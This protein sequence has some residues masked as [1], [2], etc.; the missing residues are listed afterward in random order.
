RAPGRPAGGRPRRS[1]AALLG[2]G[3]SRRWPAYLAAA[4]LIAAIPPLLLSLGT[5]F[6]PEMDEGSL[7][8][9]FNSPPG[10][11]AS[12]TE[13]ILAG[14][15]REIAATPE[16]ASWSG[17]IGDQLGFFI[18]EPNRGADVLRLKG[19]RR[20]AADAITD[21]LRRRIE[22]SQPALEIEF[23][24]LIEDVVGDLTTNPQP[25]GVRVFGEDRKVTESYAREVAGILE[26][27]PCV[28]DVKSGVVVSGS[29]VAIVPGAAAAR[30]GLSAGALSDAVTPAVAGLPAGQ[31]VRGVRAWP[32]RVVL[33]HPA[34]ASA[35]QGLVGT[36][37]PAA[38]GRW[39]MLGDLASLD[40]EP[41]ETEIARDN[42]RTMVSVTARLSGR[43]LGSAMTEI[44]RR[45]RDG[46]ALPAGMT[47]RY[48]GLWA[49]QQES[50]RGL[51][52]VLLGAT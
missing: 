23:G 19:R 16:I 27:V 4:L 34:S 51:A 20:R 18:T 32:V 9:D 28:V 7:I 13:R 25:I 47:I 44:Q 41:G 35:A 10:T 8:L 3:T 36:P 14:V 17:R 50:F 11:S 6:L 5:G 21:D 39:V 30:A 15:E 26:G 1:L 48:G 12:E 24:Q 38:P 37:V 2:A 22:A 45:I 31:I 29:N 43:D 33:A 46:V 40:V 52:A 42:L 49:E